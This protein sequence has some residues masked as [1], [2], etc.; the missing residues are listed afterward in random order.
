MHPADP[1]ARRNALAALVATAGVGAALIAGRSWYSEPVA[2]WLLED[3]ALTQSRGRLLLL[4]AGALLVLP[5]G[6]FAVYL[7]RLGSRVVASREFP[8]PGA[9]MLRDTEIVSGN[10]AVAYGRGLRALAVFLVVASLG[11]AVAVWRVALLLTDRS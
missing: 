4:G 1:K 5:L 7:W 3:P 9:L 6:F 10:A 8:P 2:T 11:L